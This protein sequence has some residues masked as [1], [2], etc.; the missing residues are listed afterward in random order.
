MTIIAASSTH[1]LNNPSLSSYLT[2]QRAL[3]DRFTAANEE[4]VCLHPL[5]SPLILSLCFDVLTNI[6]QQCTGGLLIGH[7]SSQFNGR[8][9]SKSPNGFFF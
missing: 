7:E 2:Q 5:L 9:R 6:L 8:G 1:L 3:P 4:A